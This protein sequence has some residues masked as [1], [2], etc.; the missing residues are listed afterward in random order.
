M[1]R[2]IG[3]FSLIAFSFLAELKRN[4]AAKGAF[5]FYLGLAVLLV[6]I[7]INKALGIT[8]LTPFKMVLDFFG[9]PEGY[10][11]A[12]EYLCKG[13]SGPK[14]ACDAVNSSGGDAPPPAFGDMN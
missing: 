6:G 12:M 5:R 7:L 10:D 9:I 3:L 1:A 14:W 13:G 11:A 4:W 8:G 2:L